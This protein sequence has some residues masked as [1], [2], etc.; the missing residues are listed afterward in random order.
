VF[1]DLRAGWLRHWLLGVTT[2]LLLAAPGLAW[3]AQ[4]KE[5]PGLPEEG[6]A[7]DGMILGVIHENTLFFVALG[8]FG[9]FWFLLG[10][11]RKAKI[12]RKGH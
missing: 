2:S 4:F 3:T 5:A 8:V 10:G 12:G 6:K 7:G 11:G 9:V 1:R